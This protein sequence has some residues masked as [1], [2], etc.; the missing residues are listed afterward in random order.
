[1][2][3]NNRKANFSFHFL[4]TGNEIISRIYNFY[5]NNFHRKIKVDIMTKKLKAL[6]HTQKWN[7]IF[8]ILMI[9]A[10]SLLQVY[11]IQVFMNPCNLLSSGFTGVALLIHKIGA[12]FDANISTSLLILCLNIPAAILCYKNISRRFTFLSCLQFICTSFFLQVLHFDPFFDDLILNVI[13]GGFLYGLGVVFA[14]RADG[15]TGGTDFI[16]QFVSNKIHKSIWNYVFLFN[17]VIIIIFGVLFGWVYAG[18]SIIFQ[19][20]STRTISSFYHRY[21]QVTIEITTT[22]P[23]DISSNFIKHFRHGMSI[24]E[25]YGAYSKK[26]FYICKSVVSTNEVRDVVD[27]IRTIDNQSIINTYK[28][29]HFYGKF[30]FKPIA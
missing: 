25:A 13:F 8:S 6:H 29:D 26:K 21:S 18:Y 24:T 27:L 23:E 15:S 30:Y 2:F 9:L 3:P 10:S 16:A 5:Y 19:F 14:L 4:M 28:T 17:C 20:I 1:M 22:I 11:V 12:L 7:F